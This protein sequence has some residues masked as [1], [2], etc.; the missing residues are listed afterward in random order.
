[1]NTKQLRQKILDLAIRG[2]LVPQDPSDEPASVLLERIRAEKEQLIKDKKLKR[3]KK[4]NEPIDEVPFELPEGWEWCRL[5]DLLI[6]R[7]G[8]RKPLSSSV[9]SKQIKKK[10]DYYGATGV[11]DKVDNYIFDE[12]LLLV[13]EDGANLLSKVK[14]N[15]FFAEGKYWVNNHAHILDATNKNLLDYVIIVINTISLDNYI[16]GTAQP[17]LSQENLNKI[18]IPLPPLAEQYRILQK[19]EQLLTIVDTIEQLQEELKALVK[20]TKNQVLNYAI[21]GKLTLQDPN[22]EPAEELLKRIGK[23]TATDTPYEKLPKGWVWC[24]LGDIGEIITGNT[25]SKGKE[26]FYGNDFPFFKPNDLDVGKIKTSLDSL[27]VLGYKQAKKAP[28]NSILVTCIGSIGKTGITQVEGA[29]NQQINAIIP[30]E[31]ISNYFIYYLMLS[32]KIQEQLNSKASATTIAILNK[33]KFENILIPLPPLQE[34]HRIVEK[35]ENYF[36]FLD[37]IEIQIN[38]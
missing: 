4:D 20:Q 5:G 28:K 32:K 33:S 16:T 3:D 17:K 31:Y 18:P 13:G 24:K 25:P 1:M 21:A 7:D 11:I 6:N 10:Y 19:V 2:E 22:D 34:Q 23:T 27:S 15:A 26:S 9:R 38:S 30:F 35:I 8:E 37:T 36:S 29:F 14:P 12:K